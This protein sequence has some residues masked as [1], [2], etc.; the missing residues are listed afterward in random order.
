LSLS[1]DFFGF[2]VAAL[3]CFVEYAHII[4]IE[5]SCVG[6]NKYRTWIV[7]ELEVFYS[8]HH[9][10]ERSGED[11]LFLGEGMMWECHAE[12]FLLLLREGK[13][14]ISST[15]RSDDTLIGGVVDGEIIDDAAIDDG[16][17]F[18]ME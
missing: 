10:H 13:S 5:I 2:V 7:G 16:S 15:G 14:A 18:V 9:D 4:G 8:T 11:V 17:L 1:K 12:E 3:D 6:A